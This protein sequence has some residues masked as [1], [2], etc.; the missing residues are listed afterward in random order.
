MQ[1]R[2]GQR[3]KADVIKILGEAL[4]ELGDYARKWDQT[5]L[6]EPLNRYETDL[7]NTVGDAAVL[8]EQSNA[9]NTKVLADLFHMN[10]EEV[11]IAKSIRKFAD[12]IGHVHFVDSNRLPAG[13]GHS[14]LSGAFTALEQSGFN[15]YLAVESFPL[16]D[17]AT[18]AGNAAD[19]FRKL[20]PT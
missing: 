3:D 2:A 9:D 12:S 15:G 7:I 1:G 10:I 14:D 17:Q 4:A 18:A 20:L 19:Y 6:Y 5:L 16:P 13:C 8:L 11:D